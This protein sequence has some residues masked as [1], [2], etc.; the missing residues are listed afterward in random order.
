MSLAE[1]LLLFGGG[2]LAGVINTLAGNGS[3]ITLSLLIFM[4]LPAN[5]ANATNRIG[6]LLQT[7][8]A[9]VSLRRTK[10]TGMLF[11]DSYWFVIPSVLG[12]VIGAFLAIDIDADVLRYTI[13]GIM[14]VLLFTLLNRPKKWLK[15]TDVSKS[16]KTTLNWIVVFLTAV[17]GGFIQMG[18]GIIL[19]SVLVLLAE[20]SLRDANI[21][22]LVLTF[23][24]VVPAFFIF[25]FSG[26]MRWEPGLAIA[27]GQGLGAVIGARYILYLPKANM[28]VRWL[29]II[30]LSV[31]ALVL[32]DIPQKLANML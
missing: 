26:D 30:I 7:M 5:I 21:I 12:S 22:K 8:T 29:L 4:G 17:Y 3:A 19:L 9:V 28:Y 13:G 32:L 15:A 10:R 16:H 18:I 25:W 23:I 11:K 27:V 31:S 1:Y 14:L 20:Y 2:L 6:A 24:F